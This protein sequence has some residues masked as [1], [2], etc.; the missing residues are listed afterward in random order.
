MTVELRQP[1][2]RIDNPYFW[3]VL[4]DAI[5]IFGGWFPGLGEVMDIVLGAAALVIFEDPLPFIVPAGVELVL[6]PGPLDIF[7]SY[8][9][10]VFVLNRG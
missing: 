9:A 4:L 6:L 8:V 5:D 7:P 3:A 2:D 1:F 10:T